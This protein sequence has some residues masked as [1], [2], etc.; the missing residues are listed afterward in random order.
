MRIVA[1]EVVIEKGVD[2]RVATNGLAAMVT[3]Y[4]RVLPT[5][6]GAGMAHSDES[7]RRQ[8]ALAMADLFR[9]AGSHRT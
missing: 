2:A 1:D 9:R 8:V 7:H 4:E 5:L 3:E 6:A